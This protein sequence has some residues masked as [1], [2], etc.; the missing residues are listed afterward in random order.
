MFVNHFAHWFIDFFNRSFLML[1]PFIGITKTEKNLEEAESKKMALDD[2]E[3]KLESAEE[4][5]RKEVI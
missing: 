3:R 1:D 5:A 4:D 2:A